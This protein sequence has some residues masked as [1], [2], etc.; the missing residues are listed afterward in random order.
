MKTRSAVAILVGA[1]LVMIAW[2]W[3]QPDAAAQQPMGQPNQGMMGGG[4]MMGGTTQQGGQPAGP[5][6]TSPQQA[7]GGNPGA[8]G[9][10]PRMSF[11]ERPLIT[12]MLSLQEQL[13]LSPEQV[14]QL[15]RLRSAFEKEAIRQQADIQAAEVDLSDL[16]AAS[17]PDLGKIEAQ[18]NKIATLTG[19]LRFARIKT[20]EEGRAVLSQEQWQKFQSMA[21]RMGPRG[22]YGG[23]WRQGQGRSNPYEGYGMMGPGMMGGHGPGMMGGGMMGGHGPGGMMGG[24]GPYG[25]YGQREF[26]SNGEQIYYTGVSE[27]NGP[28]ARVGGPP[29]VQ[30][31]GAGCVACHGVQGRGGVPV[32]MGTAIPE[33]IR[34]TALTAPEQDKGEGTAKGE[35]EEKEHPPYTDATIGRAITQGLDESGKPLDRTMPR[36]QMSSEDVNDVIAY[37]KTLK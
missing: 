3:I 21:P 29:W 19:N 18:V 33:D 35:K 16:L 12:E 22:P 30:H 23:R 8:R 2:A 25:G 27:K 24:Y 13:G 17:P 34:Y 11:F 15:Q 9:M 5:G 37:L 20:L 36:W 6:P 10:G 7:P 26:S 32:M 14:Q 31:F 4:G 28:I 1:A